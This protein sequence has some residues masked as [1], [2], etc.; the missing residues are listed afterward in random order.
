MALISVLWHILPIVSDSVKIE[1]LA[2]VDK[3]IGDL[4]IIKV[5]VI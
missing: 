2:E 5:E 4:P 1:E 3:E